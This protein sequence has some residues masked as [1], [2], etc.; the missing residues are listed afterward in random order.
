MINLKLED[1]FKKLHSFIKIS[2]NPFSLLKKLTYP[3]GLKEYIKSFQFRHQY[4]RNWK[5]KG[6]LPFRSNF[7]KGFYAETSL[8][9]R[10]GFELLK[11][12]QDSIGVNPILAYYGINQ[13]FSAIID[14]CF[15]GIY[16]SRGHGIKNQPKLTNDQIE[17]NLIL[18]KTKNGFFRKLVL[19]LDCMGE[20]SELISFIFFNK[21]DSNKLV[22]DILINQGNKSITIDLIKLNS[23][24]WKSRHNSSNYDYVDQILFRYLNLF[25]FCSALRYNPN[26]WLILQEGTHQIYNTYKDLDDKIIFDVLWLLEKMKI[27]YGKPGFLFDYNDFRP[28]L[29]SF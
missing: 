10:S 2:Q 25:A 6:N 18:D 24:Y 28:N 3:F 16:K 22:N 5:E 21:N 29:M 12:S 19:L 7:S 8:K 14:I 13:I 4:M 9:F 23:N 1:S 27:P 20:N 17:W 15:D 26:I 11:K